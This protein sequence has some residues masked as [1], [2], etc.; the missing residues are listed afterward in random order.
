[1]CGREKG[2]ELFRVGRF[3]VGYEGKYEGRGGEVD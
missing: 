1:V 2:E 3:G